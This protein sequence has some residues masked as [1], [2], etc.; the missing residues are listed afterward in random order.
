[1]ADLFVPL[2]ALL[3]NAAYVATAPLMLAVFAASGVMAAIG[4][5]WV[6]SQ[7]GLVAQRFGAMGPATRTLEDFEMQRSFG[8][9]IVGPMTR[10]CARM[11]LRWTPGGTLEQYRRKL[12][13]AGSASGAE[14]RDFLGTKGLLAIAFGFGM[15]LVLGALG[16]SLPTI[17]PAILGAVLG[18]YLPNLLLR[19]RIKRRQNNVQR[20][21][22]DALD[23]LTIC[24]EAGLGFDAAVGRVHEK[25][26]DELSRE[27]GRVLT[28]MRMGRARRDALRTL[29]E[30]TDVADVNT[31]VSAIVQSEQLG[32]SIS[33]VLLTQAEQMRV[34]R[35]QR[36]EELAHKAPIKMLFPMV[37][38]IF[39]AIFVVILGPAIPAI[40]KQMS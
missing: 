15:P 17:V 25:R 19:R 37:F 14:V 30:R 9:R 4:G 2:S 13:L 36:A 21:L 12:I 26:D 6:I 40:L 1:V 28:E 7:P 27:F 24:V 18:F 34:R 32:V 23:L 16:L 8:D 38:L 29:G 10:A 11:V 31:F 3:S 35:R 20:A 39:P 33:K 22:P 5:A